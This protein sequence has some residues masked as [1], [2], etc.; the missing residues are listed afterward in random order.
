[1]LFLGVVH[2]EEAPQA[3]SLNN[4]TR[5]DLS[6]VDY[7]PKKNSIT[8]S[9]MLDDQILFVVSSRLSE[10]IFFLSKNKTID[11]WARQTEDLS[12]KF[13][14]EFLIPLKERAKYL[15]TGDAAKDPLLDFQGLAVCPRSE[16]PSKQ[17]MFVVNGYTRDILQYEVEE[18]QIVSF[19]NLTEAIRLDLEKRDSQLK[20][21]SFFERDPASSDYLST[22]FYGAENNPLDQDGFKGIA[23]D[24]SSNTL[25]IA[26]SK[27]PAY[28]LAADIDEGTTVNV[29]PIF[30]DKGSVFEGDVEVS[31]IYFENN[32]L[33]ILEKRSGKIIEINTSTDEWIA[34]YDFSNWNN[35][36][37][38]GG[39][40]ETLVVKSN[41]SEKKFFVGFRNGTLNE[42]GLELFSCDEANL[43]DETKKKYL[44]KKNCLE[45]DFEKGIY[46]ENAI[47]L[48]LGLKKE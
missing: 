29:F 24:C 47:L 25:Y 19:K 27:H 34:T 16:K 48:E 9:A 46:F 32:S 43:V 44:N 45:H 7:A 39:T 3:L 31:D 20:V 38:D 4:L 1:M 12:N 23:V 15:S 10:E 36:F 8:G 40:P 11:P 21:Q 28:V 26:K 33:Y 14:Q 2:A 37:S 35:T 30:K 22:F 5:L 13:T 6:A 42:K 17:A 18:H 41:K